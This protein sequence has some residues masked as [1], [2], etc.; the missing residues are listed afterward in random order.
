E[1]NR[2]GSFASGNRGDDRRVAVRAVRLFGGEDFGVEAETFG[3]GRNSL[4]AG[5]D[6]GGVEARPGNGGN[7]HEVREIDEDLIG[8]GF[9]FCM[10]VYTV[11]CLSRFAHSPK[12]VLI[13][14]SETKDLA[15][16]TNPPPRRQAK[17]IPPQTP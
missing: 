13:R 5:G 2:R 3:Q 14:C 1:K 9:Q 11:K 6:P 7:G 10:Q 17:T 12:V 16:R 15:R 4:G 8:D